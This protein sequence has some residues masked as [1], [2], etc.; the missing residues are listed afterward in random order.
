MENMQSLLAR[1]ARLE[2]S[3]RAMQEKVDAAIQVASGVN[4]TTQEKIESLRSALEPLRQAVQQREDERGY[5]EQ[6]ARYQGKHPRSCACN[7]CLGL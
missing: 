4:M 2:E 1:I 7:R 5:A 3:N 6:G